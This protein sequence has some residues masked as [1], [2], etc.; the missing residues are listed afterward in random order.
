MPSR[1]A[2]GGI[3]FIELLVG[4]YNNEQM[5][6][7]CQG[8]YFMPIASKKV[9]VEATDNWT[10]QP[11]LR[12]VR[13][14]GYKSI[15]LCDVELKPLTVL[16]GRN[17]S[18]KSNFV[19]A[20]SFLADAMDTSVAEAARLHG[21]PDALLFRGSKSS[22]IYLG[23]EAGITGSGNTYRADY[24]IM[25]TVSKTPRTIEV[26]REV[27]RIRDLQTNNTCGFE[28]KRGR[29]TWNGLENLDRAGFARVSASWGKGKPS[30][31]ASYYRYPS[32]QFRPDRLLL[33]VI[34]SQ[35][36]VDV[37]LRLGASGFYN[38]YPEVIRQPQRVDASP[39]LERDGRNL[40][41]AIEALKEIDK[42][43]IERIA[44]Y[45]SVITDGIDKFDVVRIDDFETIHFRQRPLGGG[46]STIFNAASM[47]DGT[48]RALATLVAA[49]QIVLPVGAGIA[50][51]EEPETA[52]HPAAMRALMDAL[53]EATTDKQILVTTHSADL[54]GGRDLTPGQVLVVRNRGGRTLISPIDA[55]S[56]EIVEKELYTLADLQRMD[57]LDLDEADL[58]R[59]A[60]MSNGA[61]GAH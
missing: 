2:L 14:C 35:P 9:D 13:I 29:I 24:S 3:P 11:F 39:R 38:F 60:N 50:A 19:D 58:E 36:F 26:E 41:R 10:K 5:S 40:A 33:A 46:K 44:S 48:L 8:S 42:K 51:I 22:R 4:L 34:G 15:E 6:E 56:R 53:D 7:Q 52:I 47:S 1:S 32:D 57:R 37:G 59:Q 27:M 25:L 18:G 17:A 43:R 20:L 16:V 30:G 49:F 61:A 23:I 31:K 28:V 54:L 12:R 21:G 55:A 45:L